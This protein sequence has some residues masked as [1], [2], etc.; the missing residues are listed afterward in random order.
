[1]TYVQSVPRLVRQHPF[2]DRSRWPRANLCCLCLLFGFIVAA[3]EA[4]PHIGGG[5][6]D[7]NNK[8]DPGQRT[9]F[10]RLW[11]ETA[12]DAAHDLIGLR[13]VSDLILALLSSRALKIK[14]L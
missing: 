7:Q 1:M 6:N 14:R 11:G 5:Q 2:F 12:I 13:R 8:N 10:A 9:E 3:C 4:M